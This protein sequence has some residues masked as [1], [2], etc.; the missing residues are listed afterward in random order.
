MAYVNERHF[1]THY[2]YLD[3]RSDSWKTKISQTMSFSTLHPYYS[4]L[5]KSNSIPFFTSLA[6]HIT[7]TVIESRN[8][9]MPFL[10]FLYPNYHTAMMQVFVGSCN[11]MLF[12]NS[13]LGA[14]SIYFRA[15]YET[16]LFE[17]P[18]GLCQQPQR[19][20]PNSVKVCGIAERG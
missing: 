8:M 14:R 13:F 9:S 12:P 11:E 19:Y 10:N 7:T 3:S 17:A 1:Y 5:G 20:T 16:S 6:T 4:K 15:N 18:S 2:R